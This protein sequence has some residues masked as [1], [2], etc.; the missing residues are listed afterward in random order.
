MVLSGVRCGIVNMGHVAGRQQS[1]LY[2]GHNNLTYQLHMHGG[3][4]LSTYTQYLCI[5]GM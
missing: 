3:G 2:Y 4:I 5:V 1:W